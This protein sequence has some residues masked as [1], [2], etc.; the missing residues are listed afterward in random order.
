MAYTPTVWKHRDVVTADKLNKI[1]N[2]IA[3]VSTMADNIEP[4]YTYKGSVETVGDLPAGASK[5]DLY[6]VSGVQYVWD[7]TEWLNI[8]ASVA[9]TE[10]QID[11]L[12]A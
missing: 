11:A 10:E 7:G 1:E 9:I 3:E 6:T 4:G 12:F 8:E 5:G 2:G